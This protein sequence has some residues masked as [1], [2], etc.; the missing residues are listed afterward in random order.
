MFKRMLVRRRSVVLTWLISYLAILLLPLVISFY[1]FT[2][3]SRTLKS[4]IHQANSSLLSQV[5]EGMDNYFQAMQRLNFE[6][7]WNVRVQDLLY[8]NKYLA[9]PADYNY[10]TYQISQ[11]LKTY[12]SAYT[13]IDSFYIYLKKS[14]TVIMPSKVREG[15]YAYSLLHGGGSLSYE[16]WLGTVGRND[17]HGF[18]PVERIDDQGAVHKSV[19]YISSYTLDKNSSPAANVIMVDQERMLGAIENVE[20]FS[21][22]HVFIL[23]ENNRVLVS[24]S[25]AAAAQAIPFDKMVSSSG[26]VYATI[27]D[28]NYEVLYMKSQRSGLKYVSMIPST[29]YWG[30]AELIRNL[31]IAGSAVSILGG[32]LLMTFFV[33]RNYNPVRRLVQAFSGKADLGFGGAGGNEFQFL[34]QAFD[35]TLV[36]MDTMQLQM[37]RQKHILRSN[38]LARLLKGR[39]D[40]SIPVAESLAA[41]HM[42]FVSDDFA[43]ILL[44]AESAEEFY[45][46]VEGVEYGD[47][48]RLLHFI[49]TNVVEEIVAQHNEGYV[50]EIDDSL[51]CLVNFRQT[52]SDERGAE[53]QRIA[54]EAQRFL[55]DHY[56]IHLTLSISSV[57]SRI[58][59]IPQAYQEALDAMEYKLV[60]GSKEILSYEAL[61][62]LSSEE[63]G[64][65]YYYPLQVEQQLINYLKIGDFDKA[66]QTLDEIIAGN[67]D[68]PAVSVAFARCLMLNM[69]STMIKAVS[70]LGNIHDSFLVRNPQLIKR[71]TACET[72]RD[73]QQQMT[74][75]LKTVCDYTAAKRQHQLQASRQAALNNR[76]GDIAALIRERYH[77]PNLNISMIGAH[78]DMKRRT[79]PSCSKIIPEKGCSTLLTKRGSK[80][81][82]ASSPRRTAT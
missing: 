55:A 39:P 19:A 34:Q 63:S 64:F 5:R 76:I 81:P 68:R 8:S 59:G 17:F 1:V 37:E 71:L 9:H 40:G 15:A 80:R 72:I 49:I 44:Y 28:R 10:D 54:R 41:F 35:K 31:T 74:Q 67:F 3:S 13:L 66:K 22:G 78:F 12:Q 82:S 60:V 70:E 30:K 20:L 52:P 6:I 21:E 42:R 38:F 46:T 62:R 58:E 33:R 77:D 32:V 7:T 51:A 79:C 11:D 2:V 27:Q 25:D 53:L 45:A 48:R 65:G 61:R 16:D 24:N 36:K 43:V 26:I 57:H 75:F 73:M 50:A 29:L 23:N 56:A 4:E 18:V 14:N 47:K 69:V